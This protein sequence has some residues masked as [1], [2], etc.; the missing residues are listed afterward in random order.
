MQSEELFPVLKHAD[1][2][3]KKEKKSKKKR[4]T[5]PLRNVLFHST[6]KLLV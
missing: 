1:F 5:G 2:F 4:K 3:Q 6:V